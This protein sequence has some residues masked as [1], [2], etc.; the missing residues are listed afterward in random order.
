MLICTTLLC[1]S[2][3]N[4]YA[5]STVEI[6]QPFL[7]TLQCRGGTFTVSVLVPND[8]F[9]HDN[10]FRVQ[11]SD[12][13]GSFSN[14]K[15]IALKGAFETTSIDCFL[16]TNILAATGYRI[17]IV[18]DKPAYTSNDNGIDIRI[19]NYPDINLTS[20]SPVCENSTIVLGASTTTPGVTTY[21]WSGPNNFSSNQQAPTIASAS[22]IKE[23]TYTG[24][25]T[26]YGCATSD[27]IPVVVQPPPSNIIIN[28]E[29]DVCADSPL[30]LDPSCNVCNITG[31]TYKWTRPN[32]STSKQSALNI[33]KSAASD[34]GTYKLVVSLGNCS[35]SATFT[36]TVKPLPDTPSI[37]S[38]SPICVGD[39]L[40]L[41]GSTGTAGVS[42][43]WEGPNGF[44][45]TGASTTRPNI[46]YNDGGDYIL[47]ARKDGCN[48]K[49]A[50][51]EIKVGAPLVKVP[52]VGDTTLCPGDKLQLSGQTNNVTG[53]W[54]WTGPNGVLVTQINRT[55]AI[56]SVEAS[57]AGVY[58]LTRE[59]N[60]C[61]SQPSTIT[62]IIPDI[63]KPEPANNGPLCI[64]DQLELTAI[65]TPGATYSWTGPN[66][67]TSNAQNPELPNIQAEGKGVYTVT[68]TLDYCTESDTTSV[69]VTQKPII[70]EIGSNS[71]VCTF[72]QLML[73]SSSD[74]ADVTY[75]WSGPQ[76][77]SSE[78]QNPQLSFEDKNAG[79]YSLIV[80]NGTCPSDAAST[81][82][83]AKEGPGKTKVSN[84]GPLTEGDQLLLFAENGKDSVTYLWEGPNGYTST[85]QNPKIEVATYSNNGLYRLTT[86]YNGCSITTETLVNV[87]DILGI[88]VDLYPNPNTGKFTVKGISQADGIIEMVIFN[89]L[90][91]AVYRTQTETDAFKFSKEIDLPSAS[92]GVYV[93][94]LKGSG[95]TRKIRFTVVRQ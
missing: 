11:L 60:G 56:G 53:I 39:T 18:A 94:Q 12:S 38:N 80:Y 29:T 90:G 31:V 7:D 84:N 54:Q 51:K 78:E 76:N 55:M 1:M 59:L 15:Q 42:Y 58:S 33:L 16:D 93:L 49:P 69:D 35:D 66:G 27:T 50:T 17:R 70:T 6:A 14:P 2:Y 75:K 72:T 81:D 21:V 64:G 45:S 83:I 4:S 24:Q 13:N 91:R 92:S 62:V 68:T 88:V 19:S 36:V 20:N 23:G 10:I 73:N 61:K 52:I 48:S 37:S 22:S 95:I 28:S 82:V 46:V 85:E 25:V 8:T 57:D 67:Y 43:L 47:Y 65:E 40:K 63:K 34:A 9:E 77:F 41:S 26:V 74:M 86:S 79:T 3:N 32:N 71:P 89:H 44:S 87:K 30:T 5:Q